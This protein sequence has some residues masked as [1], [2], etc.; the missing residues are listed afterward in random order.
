[1]LVTMTYRDLHMRCWLA[2]GQVSNLSEPQFFLRKTS[3]SERV[4]N[5]LI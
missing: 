4:P 2:V 3:T 1:M 5:S